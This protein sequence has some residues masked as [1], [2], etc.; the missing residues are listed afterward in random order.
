MKQK[1][2]AVS[3]IQFSFDYHFV[4]VFIVPL[5]IQRI[6]NYEFSYCDSENLSNM[7][8]PIL[9]F[10]SLKVNSILYPCRRSVYKMTVHT[11]RI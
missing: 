11:L 4:L 2:L 9:M 7:Q 3:L 6:D 10:T 8:T 1:I 5:A